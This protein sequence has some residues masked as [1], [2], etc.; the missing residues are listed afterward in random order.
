[1]KKSVLYNWIIPFA[2]LLALIIL[3]H[4]AALIIGAELILPTPEDAVR[5]LVTVIR[6]DDFFVAV[7]STALRGIIGFAISF[8]LAAV[9]AIIARLSYAAERFFSP[10]VAVLRA[11]PTMSVILLTII[12]F[13]SRV[14]PVF[15]GF[16]IIFPI[17]YNNFLSAIKGVNPQLVEMSR[18]Y[19]VS[20]ADMVTK[21]FLPAIAP[22]IIS[23]SSAAISLNI[24]III[25]SEVLA[26]TSKSIGMA[27]QTAR[28]FVDT[29]QLM[30]WTIV[31]V[32]LSFAL[33][34]AVKAAGALFT[35]RFYAT[36]KRIKILR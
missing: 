12:W 14:A 35:R 23:S 6:G 27:M 33:E 19:R 18:V 4:I 21:L 17:M 22:A 20:R 28:I 15:I 16:L 34:L 29:A 32:V 24:K 5:E 2:A 31:A 36:E 8:L 10:V 9:F 7:G 11:V 1:M 25:A 13:N 30:A 3:W 26:Q